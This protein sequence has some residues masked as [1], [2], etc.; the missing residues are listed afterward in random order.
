MTTDANPYQPRRLV[1]H[2][3]V[4]GAP[5]ASDAFHEVSQAIVLHAGAP[6]LCI[7]REL[8][9]LDVD[10][11]DDWIARRTAFAKRARLLRTLDGDGAPELYAALGHPGHVVATIEEHAGGVKLRDLLRALPHGAAPAGLAL[12]LARH[13]AE[14]FRTAANHDCGG[15]PN[16]EASNV[17]LGWDGR[18]RANVHALRRQSRD[19]HAGA[20]VALVTDDIA[21]MAPEQVRGLP[22]TRA[23][24]FVIGVLL[25]EALLGADPF[26]GLSNFAL[27]ERIVRADL[28]RPSTV[29]ALPAAVNELVARCTQRDE[30]DRYASWTELVAAIERARAGAEPFAERE[31][32][33]LLERTFP[34]ERA[35]AGVLGDMAATFDVDGVRAKLPLSSL[36][37]VA[38][39]PFPLRPAITAIAPEADDGG[40]AIYAGS[41]SRPMLRAGKLL[42]DA[43]PV[44][45]AEYARFVTDSGRAPP[46]HWNGPAPRQAIYEAPVTGVSHADALAYAAWAGKRLPE[47]HEWELALQHAGAERLAT[48][49]VWEWTNSSRAQGFVVRGGRWRDRP[50]LPAHPENTS[51]ESEA[52]PDVGFRCVLDQPD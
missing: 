5:L 41:D 21:W 1:G 19:M 4:V 51:W 7:T 18:A 36:T 30:R 34:D 15:E 32:A 38:I 43:R 6:R 48:G 17:L 49:A 14:A 39:E 25:T 20:M 29:R 11:E 45:N 46:P 9:R 47:D 44:T 10:D 3:V 27:L 52:M 22:T 35:A 26:E 13:L 2:A 42:V 37:N 24:M 23:G 50:D 16:V 40:D 28:P 12:L 8:K 31:L 33:L